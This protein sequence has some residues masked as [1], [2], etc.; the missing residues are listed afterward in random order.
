MWKKRIALLL[1]A[2]ML[3]LTL[4]SPATASSGTLHCGTGGYPKTTK[5]GDPVW[6]DHYVQSHGTI[7]TDAT[8]VYWDFTTGSKAWSVTPGSGSGVCVV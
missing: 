1:T 8:T 7:Y 6:R 5:S 2:A 3:S 4:A